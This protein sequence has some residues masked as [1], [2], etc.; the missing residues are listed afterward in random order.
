MSSF[1]I[2]RSSNPER[3]C[4]IRQSPAA[5]RGQLQGLETDQ[6][7]GTD[8]LKSAADRAQDWG[9]AHCEGPATEVSNLQAAER[10]P[11]VE[12]RLILRF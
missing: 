3:K 5:S 1:G 8:W 9:V 7:G 12:P 11:S 6:R 4:L 10:W 2:S